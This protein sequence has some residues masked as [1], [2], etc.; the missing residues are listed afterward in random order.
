MLGLPKHLSDAPHVK[1][2]V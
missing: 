1:S 2:A